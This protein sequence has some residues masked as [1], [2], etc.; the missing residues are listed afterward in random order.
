VIASRSEQSASQ[1]PSA[2]SAVLVTVKLAAYAGVTATA[3]PINRERI[4]NTLNKPLKLGELD[5]FVNMVVS[6]IIR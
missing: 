4:I 2:V 5:V 6:L 1:V 3:P